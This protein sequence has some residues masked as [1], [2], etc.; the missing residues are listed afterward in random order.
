M[1]YELPEMLPVIGA[2]DHASCAPVFLCA[3]VYTYKPVLRWTSIVVMLKTTSYQ[4]RNLLIMSVGQKRK[5]RA[6]FV[7]FKAH[8]LDSVRKLYHLIGGTMHVEE[9]IGEDGNGQWLLSPVHERSLCLPC[10]FVD[11]N[12]CYDHKAVIRENLQGLT[13][14]CTVKDTVELNWTRPD[15]KQ[16]QQQMLNGE[17]GITQLVV[18]LYGD[19]VRNVGGDGNNAKFYV[20][21]H[22]SGL[23][24]Q[25]YGSFIKLNVIVQI[26]AD[27]VDPYI[28]ELLEQMHETPDDSDSVNATL[29][30]VRNVKK[31]LQTNKQLQD[32]LQLL[33]QWLRDESLAEKF[34]SD[35]NLLS[36]TAGVIDLRTGVLRPRV[37]EAIRHMQ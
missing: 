30:A 6:P 16:K 37:K 31:A 28:A 34:N 2:A 33:Y 27:V 14:I 9:E 23:W 18:D 20:Y 10:H 15:Y 25:Q 13:C 1:C 19:I 35:P 26:V 36:V 22:R 7:S 17:T 11:G 29:K 24:Q 8:T 5:D 32:I 3:A 4:K 21:N 12:G